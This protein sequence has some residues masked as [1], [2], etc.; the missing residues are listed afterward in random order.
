MEIKNFYSFIHRATVHIF[1]FA[2]YFMV[3]MRLKKNH[4]HS[5]R[6]VFLTGGIFV[7]LSFLLIFHI[8]TPAKNSSETTL[9]YTANAHSSQRSDENDY[10]W[11][12]I[13]YGRDTL[14]SAKNMPS[15]ERSSSTKDLSLTEEF[16]RELLSEYMTA[17]QKGGGKIQS[18]SEQF[19]AEDALRLAMGE[20]VLPFYNGENLKIVANEKVNKTLYFKEVGT[21]TEKLKMQEVKEYHIMED[22]LQKRSFGNNIEK[23]K[24]AG[25]HFTL[26]AEE[27]QKIS[28][29]E[30]YRDIHK[31]LIEKLLHY[32]Y[33]LSTISF[34]EKDPLRS[35]VGIGALSTI[36]N[37]V[38]IALSSFSEM[39]TAFEFPETPENPPLL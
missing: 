12:E 35:A 4:I 16:S 22:I 13:L 37:E 1:F 14:S 30:E 34:L 15:S 6:L 3:Y 38:H 27:L 32:G 23:L 21:I 24:N 17:F 20:F 39:R 36:Q 5:G 33:T 28:V 29:P 25:E 8:H 26:Y 31:N 19:L 11:E 2:V 7:F 18:G 9:S 10:P